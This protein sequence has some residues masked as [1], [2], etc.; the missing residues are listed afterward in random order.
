M[1]TEYR[2]SDFSK[3]D[4]EKAAEFIKIAMLGYINMTIDEHVDKF[5][6]KIENIDFTGEDGFE[7][8]FAINTIGN[9]ILA[10]IGASRV[11]REK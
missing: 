4:R 5:F 6:K 10:A 11:M 9:D 2:L 7:I 8:N 3:E 1:A